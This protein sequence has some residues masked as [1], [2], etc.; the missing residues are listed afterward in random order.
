MAAQVG[1][2]AAAYSSL[3]DSSDQW[4]FTNDDLANTPSQSGSDYSTSPA[5]KM[6]SASDE[7][8]LRLRGC[9]FIHNVV[10]RLQMHQF[11]A[12]TAC[13]LFHRFYMRQSLTSYH[14]YQMAGACVLLA[15]KIE[16]NRRS[17]NEISLAC[18]YVALKGRAKEA[19]KSQETWER[20]LKRQEIVLLQNCCF[21]MEVT[22]PYSFIDTLALEFAVP[23]FIAKSATAHVNDCLRSTICLRYPPRIIAVAALYL[24]IGIHAYNFQG[25][26]FESR[27]V[28]LPDNAM[29]E[30]ELCAMDM[31]AFYRREEEAEKEA[32]RIQHQQQRYSQQRPLT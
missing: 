18:A 25:S 11:V 2:R 21:D 17:L 28:S 3:A 9:N 20:L 8:D 29:S 1:Y 24:A 31:L 7:Q 10:Q 16:E 32:T 6:L 12:S 30:V 5:A 15:S 26:L 4:Y 23:V 19:A 22:H 13:V 27:H 14:H